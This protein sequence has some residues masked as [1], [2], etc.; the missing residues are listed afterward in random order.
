MIFCRLS[1]NDD[2]RTLA[3]VLREAG[4]VMGGPALDDPSVRTLFAHLRSDPSSGLTA[5]FSLVYRGEG[6]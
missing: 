6:F 1:A 5:T 3:P 4:R 2:S